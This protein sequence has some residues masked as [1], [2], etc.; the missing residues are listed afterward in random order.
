MTDEKD[1]EASVDDLIDQNLKRVYNSVLS[2]EV[3]DRFAKLLS[4]LQAGE[5]A[6]P[7]KEGDNS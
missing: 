5:A 6:S 7:R 3:P 2:E 1:K 4:Q